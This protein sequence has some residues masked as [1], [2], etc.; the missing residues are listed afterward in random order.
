MQGPRATAF[1]F[2]RAPDPEDSAGRSDDGAARSPSALPSPENR[3]RGGAAEVGASVL[4]LPENLGVLAR[5][6]TMAILRDIV[7]VPLPSF[8]QILRANPQLSHRILSLRLRQLQREG[9]LRRLVLEGRPRRIAYSLTAKGRETVPIVNA[10]TELVRRY[11]G[12]GGT[13][14]GPGGPVLEDLPGAR[15]KGQPSLP[16][17]TIGWPSTETV[18]PRR[19]A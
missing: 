13:E 12:G 18:A 4:P 7:S 14:P 17:R 10:V 3:G 15:P 9:Y 11:G 1:R 2:A 16:D 6:W 19:R 8:S 5:K